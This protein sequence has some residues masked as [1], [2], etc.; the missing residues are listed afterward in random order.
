[1]RETRQQARDKRPVNNSNSNFRT[2]ASPGFVIDNCLAGNP[3]DKPGD[4]GDI[5]P[6]PLGKFLQQ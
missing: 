4:I 1:M 2:F 3:S 5:G 6:Q